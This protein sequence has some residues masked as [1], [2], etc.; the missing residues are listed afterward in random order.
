MYYS[1][2]R[3]YS[4]EE[5]ERGS[6][7]L[8]SIWN[9]CW[10]DGQGTRVLHPHRRVYLARLAAESRD[11]TNVRILRHIVIYV[12]I[13][14]YTNYLYENINTKC[15]RFDFLPPFTDLCLNS[16]SL[17]FRCLC[18][19]GAFSQKN[20]SSLKHHALVQLVF[21]RPNCQGCYYSARCDDGF[22]TFTSIRVFWIDTFSASCMSQV[23]AFVTYIFRSLDSFFRHLCN[24]HYLSSGE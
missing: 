11:N 12:V 19:A 14:L 20:R 24:L 10:V 2:G 16:S 15:S 8:W 9:Q 6:L 22:M 3:E 5:L 13:L 7:G 21:H 18:A 1:E 4:D 23:W 17:S